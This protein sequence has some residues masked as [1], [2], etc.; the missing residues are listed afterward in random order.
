MADENDIQHGD[1]VNKGIDAQMSDWP[2]SLKEGDPGPDDPEAR[3][4]WF[5]EQKR[6]A[7]AVKEHT[8][9][10]GDDT[11]E[12]AAVERAREQVQER[13]PDRSI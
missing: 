3:T 1:L 13:F 12:E 11:G 6:V 2:D 7:E 10:E 9:S 8:S 5:R 4:E